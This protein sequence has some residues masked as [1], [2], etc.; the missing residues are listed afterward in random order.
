[1]DSGLSQAT[2]AEVVVL[3]PQR[4]QSVT[5]SQVAEQIF[6]A[7]LRL[8]LSTLSPY[9]VHIFVPTSNAHNTNDR[10]SFVT[11]S[12]LAELAFAQ[13]GFGIFDEILRVI[14]LHKI[15]SAM[16]SQPDNVPRGGAILRSINSI[17]RDPHKVYCQD[18]KPFHY[19]GKKLRAAAAALN[20][21]GY[22][23]FVFAR[24]SSKGH[25]KANL[26]VIISP[27]L[28]D[29]IEQYGQLSVEY[30]IRGIQDIIRRS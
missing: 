13:E 15:L 3:S 6:Q 29:A 19:I 16:A 18:R 1:M 26:E 23:L 25:S 11:M 17:A 20:G 2:A 5:C 8:E 7:C 28:R 12:V 30:I 21:G 14:A 24:P 9:L 10:Q 4:V 27:M 22:S